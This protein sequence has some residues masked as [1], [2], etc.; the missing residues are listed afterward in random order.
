MKDNKE[1]MEEAQE[2]L[3]KGYSDAE[4]IISDVDKTEELLNSLEEKINMIPKLGKHLSV[5]P[6]MIQMVRDYVRKKYTKAPAGTIVAIVSAL[7][8]V[9]NPFDIIP[10]A[11][12]G[13]GYFDD[14]TVI[15]VC[16]K[17]VKSDVEDYKEWKEENK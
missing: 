17:L 2:V 8:Y 9:F 6:V 7:I 10:D 16:L 14:A 13:V 11:V 12:P 3:E 4:K 5:I 1:V 15:A